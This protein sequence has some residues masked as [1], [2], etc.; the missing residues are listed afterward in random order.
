MLITSFSVVEGTLQMSN[1]LADLE[2]VLITK[3]FLMES[4]FN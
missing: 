2:A 4:G 1:F 3:D